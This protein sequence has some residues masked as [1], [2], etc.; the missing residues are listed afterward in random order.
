[1]GVYQYRRSSFWLFDGYMV[2]KH[3]D[4][5]R[6]LA[7]RRDPATSHEAAWRVREFSG[8]QQAKILSLL[9]LVGPLDPEQIA[10]YLRMEAYAVRK[11]LP[12]LEDQGV[13]QPI[14]RTSLTASGRHQRV[15]G[16][17]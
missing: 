6:R 13:A 4:S 10:A 12:E 2:V 16:A 5:T 3:F 1:M 8:S 17:V 14:G 15:W 11:R 9:K 7:R